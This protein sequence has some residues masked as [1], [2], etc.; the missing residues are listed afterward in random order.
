M[1]F[2]SE[3]CGDALWPR[4][5]VL[6]LRPPGTEFQIMCPYIYGALSFPGL[7][8]HVCAQ[9]WSKVSFIHS[10]IHSFVRSF[11]R[12]FIYPFNHSLIHSLIHSLHSYIFRTIIYIYIYNIFSKQLFQLIFVH[13]FYIITTFYFILHIITNVLLFLFGWRIYLH[14]LPAIKKY[15]SIYYTTL[16]WQHKSGC[17]NNSVFTTPPAAFSSLT[18]LIWHRLQW[19]DCAWLRMPSSVGPTL[20]KRRIR[21]AGVQCRPGL[22]FQG[23][24]CAHATN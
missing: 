19:F 5:N 2:L 9:M 3:W 12:S 23:Q 7:V 21:W 24:R 1:V 6:Y 13:I 10:F 22:P 8:K 16:M 4:G 17:S 18:C 11:V 20:G 14:G 15:L